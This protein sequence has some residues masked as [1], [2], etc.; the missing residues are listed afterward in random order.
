MTSVSQEVYNQKCN[1]NPR[2]FSFS[3]Q[4]ISFCLDSVT[5]GDLDDCYVLYKQR[6]GQQ[7]IIAIIFN[8][9]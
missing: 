9:F 2:D 8:T 3:I 1:P 4:L 5:T 6:S 7:V